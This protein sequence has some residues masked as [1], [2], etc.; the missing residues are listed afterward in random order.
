MRSTYIILNGGKQRSD[1]G[2][3]NAVADWSAAFVRI[4]GNPEGGNSGSE[5][6]SVSTSG[7]VSA[8]TAMFRS[9]GKQRGADAPARR[10]GQRSLLRQ[11]DTFEWAGHGL[12]ADGRR[13]RTFSLEIKK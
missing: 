11:Q 5:C 7:D 9:G 2:E 12:G 8:V 1:E 10:V 6:C 3:G 4:V 13:K